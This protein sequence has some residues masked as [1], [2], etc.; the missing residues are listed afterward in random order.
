MEEAADQPHGR[1]DVGEDRRVAG[2]P[3]RLGEPDQRVDLFV[4]R[5]RGVVVAELG[6]EELHLD[7]VAQ[8]DAVVPVDDVVVAVHE[9][10]V[11]AQVGGAGL[12]HVEQVLLAT[13]QKGGAHAVDQPGQRVGL[14]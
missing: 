12:G 5:D 14:L 4:R 2:Q 3:V 8:I 9:P 1:L 13:E 10:H 7:A 6:G 11:V